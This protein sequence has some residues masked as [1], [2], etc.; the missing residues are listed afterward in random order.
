[1]NLVCVQSVVHITKN[2][3]FQYVRG[4]KGVAKLK[5]KTN[6]LGLDKLYLRRQKHICNKMYQCINGMAPQILCSKLRYIKDE[7]GFRTRQATNDHLIV[8]DIRTT[9]CKRNFFYSGP[10][11]W[12]SL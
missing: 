8:P 7:H 9:Q 1:M 4:D 6:D 11:Y 12:N 2:V 5:N 10:K 3:S